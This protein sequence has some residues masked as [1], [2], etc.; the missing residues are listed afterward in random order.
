L[1]QDDSDLLVFL[2]FFHLVYVPVTHIDQGNPEN[3][4]REIH[5]LAASQMSAYIG[6]FHHQVIS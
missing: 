6:S 5:L 4:R 2:Q 3:K 1:S